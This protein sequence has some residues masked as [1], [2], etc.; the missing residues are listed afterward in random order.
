MTIS[1]YTRKIQY[2]ENDSMGF[3]HHANYIHWFEEARVDYMQQLGFGYEKS[4]AAGIDI[5]L[6]GL[7][8]EFKSL[9][10]F[11]ETVIIH[12]SFSSFNAVRMTIEYRI[13]DAETGDLRMTGETRHCYYHRQ[14]KRPVSLKKE[15]PELY[16]I[17]LSVAN[18]E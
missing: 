12:M 16:E 9:A 2:Y 13:I 1:P 5:I 4:V 3:V 10:C 6:T 11:G 7:S 14:K 18:A 15:L 17:F 8:C